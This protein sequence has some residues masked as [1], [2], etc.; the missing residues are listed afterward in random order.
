MIFFE[1]VK[2]VTLK[3]LNSFYYQR[4]YF[5]LNSPLQR[6]DLEENQTKLLQETIS[7]LKDDGFYQVRREAESAHS[8][9]V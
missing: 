6:D 8:Y 7:L 2:N 1:C 3:L 5:V 9:S 4:I